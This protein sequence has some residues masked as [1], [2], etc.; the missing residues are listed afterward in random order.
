MLRLPAI[1]GAPRDAHDSLRHASAQTNQFL[2]H[3]GITRTDPDYVALEVMD[4]VLGTGAGFTDR[5]SK[6]IRDEKGLAYT[7]FGNMTRTAGVVPGRS[8]STRARSPSDVALALAEMR[9]EV[10]GIL[11]RPPTTEELVGAKAALRGGMI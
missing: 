1:P 6:N 3:V 2:G 8:A 4:N 7:V 11:D 5:L 10:Q 9:K